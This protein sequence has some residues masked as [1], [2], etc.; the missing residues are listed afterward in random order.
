MGGNRIYYTTN[1]GYPKDEPVICY[2]TLS[3]RNC[4]FHAIN[5]SG[6]HRELAKL[7]EDDYLPAPIDA[8]NFY[9]TFNVHKKMV[10]LL[11]NTIKWLNE[12]PSTWQYSKRKTYWADGSTDKEVALDA[13]EWLK[14]IFEKAKGFNVYFDDALA[15]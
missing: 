10:K 15:W 11:D 8:D 3:Q 2:F 9:F 14:E 4:V 1:F 7:W 6:Q 5:E 12:Q 13:L